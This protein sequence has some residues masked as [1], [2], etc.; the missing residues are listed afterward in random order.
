MAMYRQVVNGRRLSSG[1][2]LGWREASQDF[3]SSAEISQP[4]AS[5]PLVAA[6]FQMAPIA[7]YSHNTKNADLSVYTANKGR[8]C[9]NSAGK[10]FDSDWLRSAQTQ[11]DRVKVKVGR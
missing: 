9:R 8:R 1:R 6:A 7:L 10:Q 5:C 11:V 2:Q 4:S 3:F